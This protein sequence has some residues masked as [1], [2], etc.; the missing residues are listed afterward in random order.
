[1]GTST[2]RVAALIESGAPYSLD[3]FLSAEGAELSSSVVAFAPGGVLSEAAIAVAQERPAHVAARAISDAPGHQCGSEPC[4]QGFEIVSGD[5]LVLANPDA[6]SVS[7][8]AVHLTQSVQDMDDSIPLIS[9]RDALLRVFVTSDAMN[10]FALGAEASF[11]LDRNLVHGTAL[12]PASAGIPTGVEQGRMDRSYNAQVPGTIMQPG[13]ELVVDLNTG[14]TTTLTGVT[15]FSATGRYEVNVTRVPVPKL[16]VVPVV[17]GNDAA[18]QAFEAV[19]RLATDSMAFVDAKRFLPIG[20]MTVDIRSPHQSSADLATRE[21]WSELLT[22]IA[23]L[24]S[25]ERKGGYYYGVVHSSSASGR[26][27]S[28]HGAAIRCDQRRLRLPIRAR[29]WAQHGPAA[30]RL[31]RQLHRSELPA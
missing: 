1:M 8:A 9:G 15:R 25:S 3:I 23:N 2:G 14:D 28:R 19:T 20:E 13:L 16:T 21:G 24:R 4:F 26:G 27:G 11:F 29:T 7:V 18:E 10:T 22:E 6:V 5:A 30:R 31:Q 17:S 12:S